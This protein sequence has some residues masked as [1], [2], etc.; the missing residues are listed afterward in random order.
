MPQKPIVVITRRIPE[1]GIKLL[2]DKG[3]RIHMYL[4]DGAPSRRELKKMVVG[5]DAIL[6]L[7][8]E[9]ID[10]EI[11]DAASSQLKIVANYAVGYDNV[12]IADAKARNVIVTNTPDVLSCAVAEHTMA[13]M[14]ACAKRIVEADRFTRAEKYKC[15]QPMLLLGKELNGKT[16]GIIGSGRIGTRV[17]YS[18]FHGFTM[19]IVYSD[20]AR[21]SQM[22]KDC[23]AK[24]MRLPQLLSTADVISLHV[25]LLPST[26]HLLDKEEFKMM[27][28]DAI[29]INTSRG[30]VVSE[31]AL[32]WALKK[33]EIMA[34]GIDVYECEPAIDCDTSDTLEL[35]KLPN[36][37][38]TPHIASGTIETRNEM[39]RIAAKNIIA[40]LSGRKPISPVN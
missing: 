23:K 16:L 7:L 35:K 33:K 6:S 27:K 36:V 34:A 1:P 30:P 12:N 28:R 11:L 21:N 13:L 18:A 25:P 8:T 38:M 4:G 5:A 2:R 3:Y 19:K 37:V 39:S 32:A 22:E 29:V 17:A 40:V 31:K 10:A 24:F 14:L 20:I 26:W 9:K 15:W